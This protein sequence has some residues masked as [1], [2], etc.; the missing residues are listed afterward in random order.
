MAA[1]KAFSL[2]PGAGPASKVRGGEISV[3]FGGQVS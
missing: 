3:T 2:Q 1:T